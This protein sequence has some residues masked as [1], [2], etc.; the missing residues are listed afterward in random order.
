MYKHIRNYIN[1]GLKIVTLTFENT[2]T[3]SSKNEEKF[4]IIPVK[5]KVDMLV[6]FFAS[7]PKPSEM[8][9]NISFEDKKFELLYSAEENFAFGHDCSAK[10][11]ADEKGSVSS[12]QTSFYQLSKFLQLHQ[13]L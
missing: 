12:I 3:Y 4:N 13:I 7:Y 5:Q 10:W 6:V 1:L 11:T 9:A 2:T 8:G